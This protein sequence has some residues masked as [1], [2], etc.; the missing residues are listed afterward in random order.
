MTP[1]IVLRSDGSL[2]LVLG[3]PGGATI[4]TNVF[5]NIS[6]VIDYG[7]SVGG[8]VSDEA[9]ARYFRFDALRGDVIIFT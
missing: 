7:M 4:I 1:S 6:N 3:S 5:Q 8:G 2:Y 9:V